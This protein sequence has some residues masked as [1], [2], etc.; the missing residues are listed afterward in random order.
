LEIEKQLWRNQCLTMKNF[1]YLHGPWCWYFLLAVI[2]SITIN[3]L[4]RRDK[5]DKAVSNGADPMVTTCA[6][7]GADTHWRNGNLHNPGSMTANKDSR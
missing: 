2:T 1:G 3:S 7:Y 4:N 6:L 5:W